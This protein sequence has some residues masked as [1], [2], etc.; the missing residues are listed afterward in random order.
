MLRPLIIAF[1]MY[2][3]IPMPTV[4]W[5]KDS[6][7]YA[8]C[9]FPFVGLVIGALEMAVFLLLEMIGLGRTLTAC[10][11]AAVPLLVTGGIHMD[12]FM[13]TADALSSHADRERKLEIMKDPHIGAFAV[14]YF[15]VYT[16]IYTGLL[17]EMGKE[18]VAVFSLG[19]FL[20]RALSGIFFTAFP[21]AKSTGLAAKWSEMTS[22]RNA[23]IIMC[24]EAVVCVLLML[25][26]NKGQA[27]L[28]V[29]F[30][31]VISLYHRHNCIKNFGGIT[32]DLAGYFLQLEELGILLACVIGGRL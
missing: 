3:R 9:F 22:K 6:M 17:S 31:A 18:S 21:N 2:S 10:V 14:I 24:A 25:A 15:G 28:A 20:S 4:D 7:R 26:A 30:S 16:L 8:I 27:L 13:D 32:G 11:L 1:S 12:G 19:F 23:V 29:I 5:D